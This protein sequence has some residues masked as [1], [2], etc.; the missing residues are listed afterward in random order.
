MNGPTALPFRVVKLGGSLLDLPD[1]PARLA[2][3]LP[4]QSPAHTVMIVGGGA[5]ADHIRHM[6]RLHGVPETVAHGLCIDAMSITAR[7]VAQWCPHS[8]LIVHWPDLCYEREYDGV[9][10]FDV[11][12][13]LREVEAQLPGVPLPHN[14]NVTSDS[15]AARVAELLRADELVLLKSTLSEPGASR[16]QSMHTGLV[17]RHFPVAAHAIPRV[18]CVNLRASGFAEVIVDHPRGGPADPVIR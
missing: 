15:I 4:A 17:D 8:R 14:W 6:D 11:Q 10:I 2:Q 16:V 9:T 7:L 13:F 12:S 1:L 5:W 3:W 18:R